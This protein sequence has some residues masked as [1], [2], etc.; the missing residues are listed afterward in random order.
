M[1]ERHP[2]DVFMDADAEF[3]LACRAY[4]DAADKLW[5]ATK[6]RSEAWRKLAD[7][8]GETGDKK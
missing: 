8:P 2:S 1:T 7:G 4:N 3:K 5:A 6:K